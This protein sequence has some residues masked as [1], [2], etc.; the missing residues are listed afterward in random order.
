MR[1]PL[2]LAVAI[3]ALAAGCGGSGATGQ[4]L[5]AAVGPHGG[6][7]HALPDGMGYVEVVV[8]S[9]TSAK[10]KAGELPRLVAYFLQ[11]DL[12]QALAPLPTGVTADLT[13]PDGTTKN[14]NLQPEGKTGDPAG[15]GRFAAAPA[16]EFGYDELRGD[17]KADL[18]GT[19]FTTS[20][21]FR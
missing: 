19:P 16:P 21:A 17:L 10:A 7:A 2:L 20:F 3:L 9:S 1:H 11:P 8:E 15:P 6:P 18:A 12:K 13:L 4:P 5:A 14:V